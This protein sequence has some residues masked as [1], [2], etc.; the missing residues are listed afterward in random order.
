MTPLTPRWSGR[1][2]DQTAS[3][4]VGA[5]GAQLNRQAA[6]DGHVKFEDALT[7]AGW[8][9][10][11]PLTYRKGSWE[12]VFDTSSWIMVCT[13]D[14]QRIFDVPVPEPHLV[15]W[16]LNLI[17]HLCETNDRLTELN[18]TRGGK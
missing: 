3:S 2:E 8:S 13:S 4:I 16:T 14:N 7:Q 15:Q 10:I 6:Q 17:D 18:S 11:Q 5:R 1:L 9:K 12:C